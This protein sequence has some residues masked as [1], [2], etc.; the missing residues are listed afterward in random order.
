MV[1]ELERTADLIERVVAQ[2]RVRLAGGVPDGSTRVVS[3]HDADA[4][5][6]ASG[7]RLRGGQG[8]R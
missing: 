7:P 5:P 2:T 4:R 3:L 1:A 6:I 8:R